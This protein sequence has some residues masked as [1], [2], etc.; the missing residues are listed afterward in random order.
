MVVF[1]KNRETMSTLVGTRSSTVPL[2]ISEANWF[3]LR[4][5]LSV[6][7]RHWR[8]W[9]QSCSQ[10]EDERPLIWRDIGIG[11]L[12]FSITDL[13]AVCRLFLLFGLC[14]IDCV[15]LRKNICFGFHLWS[16]FSKKKVVFGF[17][18]VSVFSKKKVCFCFYF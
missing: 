3:L 16:V 4:A 2:E 18:F 1:E 5:F 12:V 14:F 15:F 6:S 13:S 7:M 9:W 10:W 11:S 17:H 8:W